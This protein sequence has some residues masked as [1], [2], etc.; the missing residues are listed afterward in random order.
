MSSAALARLADHLRTTFAPRDLGVA[1]ERRTAWYYRLRGYRVI[2]R[3]L[4]FPRGEIDLVVRRGRLVVFV[5]VKARQQR[6][7]GE[8]HEAVDRAK[9]LTIADQARRYC[10]ARG[11]E[12][13]DIRFDVVSL[14]WNGWRFKLTCFTDAFTP[15]GDPKRP[16]KWV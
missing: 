8:P 13:L 2:E 12:T 14:F 1:G 5:E 9:Q 4:R 6:A 10:F 16:W 11:L 7:A 3:N 15:K